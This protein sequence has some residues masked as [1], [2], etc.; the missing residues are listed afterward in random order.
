MRYGF[1]PEAP[2]L[3]PQSCQLPTAPYAHSGQQQTGQC[4]LKR[5]GGLDGA[6][7]IDGADE[8]LALSEDAVGEVGDFT[9]FSKGY[10]PSAAPVIQRLPAT[11]LPD[12]YRDRTFTG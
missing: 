7:D 9:H 4:P 12:H 11:R 6:E 1:R 8:G 2:L 3:S 10:N 5:A